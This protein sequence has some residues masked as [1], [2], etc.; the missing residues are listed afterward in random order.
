MKKWVVFCR[1]A[2]TTRIRVADPGQNSSRYQTKGR[3]TYLVTI[4]VYKCTTR[5]RNIAPVAKRLERGSNLGF[6]FLNCLLLHMC[7]PYYIH[8]IVGEVPFK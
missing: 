8:I 1:G 5:L 4:Q 7:T 2:E 3:K 6:T